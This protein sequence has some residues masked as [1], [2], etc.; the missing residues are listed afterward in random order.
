[1]PTSLIVAL[2]SALDAKRTAG[3]FRRRATVESAQGPR[4]EVAG[5][6]FVAFASNDY[7]GLANDPRVITAARDAVSRW[8]VGAGASHLVS[9][10]FSPHAVLEDELAA[11]VAPCAGA[12]ALT[13]SSGYLANLAILSALAGRNDAIFADRLNHACL[14]DGALLA[15]AEFV[16]YPHGDMVALEQRLAASKSGRKFIATDAVFSMDGDLAPLPRLLELAN[17]YDACLVVD[18]AHGFGVLGEGRGSLAHFGIAS[19][20][21]V[22]MATLGKAAGVAGAFVA[23]HPSVI[24]TLVQ[25][26]RPYIYTTAAPPL[27]AAALRVALAVIRDDAGRR[28]HLTQLIVQFRDAASDL[29]WTVMPSMTAIQPLLVGDSG[30]AMDIAAALRERGFWVPAIRP[31]TVPQGTARLRVSL[32]AA[33]TS[34][35]IANLAS[36][37]HAVAAGEMR[38]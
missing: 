2:E 17:V 11:F 34:D 21:I 12:N 33:H 23:A 18:D 38:A 22:Y 10:H 5:R 31:P 15:R 8:G 26:A 20:R 16:R 14:N 29:P 19:E 13:F 4:V 24:E 3:L 37:L 9:G 1:M 32:S 28:A 35:D 30:A 25:T 27:L 6:E 7:L 36:A